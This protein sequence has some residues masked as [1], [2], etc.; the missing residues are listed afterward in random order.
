MVEIVFSKQDSKIKAF[1]Y[2]KGE[3]NPFEKEQNQVIHDLR[4]KELKSFHNLK[5]YFIEVQEDFDGNRNAGGLLNSM[6]EINQESEVKLVFSKSLSKKVTQ[7]VE[8]M[9]L[10]SYHFDSYKEKKDYRVSKVIIESDSST[11]NSIKNSI[12][13]CESQNVA[14]EFSN[15]PSN[16]LYPSAFVDKALLEAKKHGLKASF[17]DEKELQKKGFGALLAVGMGSIHKPRLLVLEYNGGGKK[18]IAL[19]GKGITFDTGG[20][21][22]KPGND[23]DKMKHD[24]SGASAVVGA[25]IAISQLKLK[26]NVTGVCALAENMPSG[27]SYRP[28]DIV[29]SYSGKHIEVLNTDAEGRM[30]LSDALWYASNDLKADYVIDAATLT[31]ACVVALGDVCAGLFTEDE[32]LRKV[33][34]HAGNE[35]GERL[36]E[37]PLWKE[38]DEKV[39]SEFAIV[40]NLGEA[41]Q[42]GAQSGASF[43]KKFISGKSKWAHLDIAGTAYYYKSKPYYSKGASGFATKLLVK[44]VEELEKN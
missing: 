32:T 44:A 22:L 40:K 15:E 1:I 24:K 35:T 12:I 42:A 5:E 38:Y 30:V 23:M 34:L 21:S 29:K 20:I 37:L 14:R 19:V 16:V 36:W 26:A 28:G 41:G 6:L 10:G 17:M 31:G 27:D 3:E 18:K 13:L 43:L 33:L 7:F 11:A 4:K 25:M 39:K 2:L 8:G 9:I